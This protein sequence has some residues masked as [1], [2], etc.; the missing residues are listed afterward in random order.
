[1]P[2]D[3]EEQAQLRGLQALDTVLAPGE[4][5]RC[6]QE[7]LRQPSGAVPVGPGD[8]GL[9]PR[10]VQRVHR[11]VLQGLRLRQAAA[12]DLHRP[13]PLQSIPVPA[14]PL[15]HEELRE[16]GRVLRVANADHLRG[17][18][19]GAQVAAAARAGLAPQD[20][21]VLPQV[22]TQQHLPHQDLRAEDARSRREAAQSDRMNT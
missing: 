10:R 3:R 15:V 21:E 4:E 2:G 22:S 9:R 11:K 1:M 6:G 12:E 8:D 17:P 5:A 16:Q 20:S 14:L 19:E 13:P 7:H 18:L